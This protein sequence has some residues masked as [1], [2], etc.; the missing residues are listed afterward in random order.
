M[1]ARCLST[2]E[3]LDVE[4]YTI[5]AQR[6]LAGDGGSFPHRLDQ[7]RSEL[8]TRLL[9]VVDRMSVSGVQEKL[10]LKLVEGRLEPTDVGG[11][12]ILKLVGA[13][14]PLFVSDVP[15]NEH[16]T[17]LVAERVFGIEVPP[18][19]LVRLADGELAYLVKRFDSPRGVKVPQE[20]FS[21]LMERTEA[22]HG[23][24]YKYDSSYEELGEALRR[25]NPDP[26][27]TER[28]FVQLLFSYAISNGDAHL[29]NVS[30]Y[31]PD[32][33]GP[34]VLTPAYDLLCTSLHIPTEARLALDLFKDGFV[35]PAFEGYGFETYA[36]F[37][38]LARRF[39]IP[40]ARARALMQP[41]VDAQPAVEDL[42]ARSFLS[43]EARAGYLARYHD[44]RK[45][46][47]IGAPA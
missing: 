17:M 20:D 43:S 13:D 42:V 15:A 34:Y 39:G 9:Q 28:L 32:P 19:G 29:K 25:V 30:V 47:G 44:R 23:R 1:T 11:E 10:S 45:A 22:T 16:V 4:G 36:C 8:L 18:R 41:F 35:T 6:R 46:L 2:L 21:Q 3:P 38:E 33:A 31:R 40:V 14:L 5:D 24:N 26:A 27:Q 12:F 7:R 37:A